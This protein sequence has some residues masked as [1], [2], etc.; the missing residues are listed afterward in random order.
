MISP[1]VDKQHGT[2]RA[3]AE[4][5]TRL[6]RKHDV[7]IDLYAQRVTDELPLAAPNVRSKGIGGAN[8]IRWHRVSSIPGPHLFQF[9]WWHFANRFRRRADKRK[10]RESP[11]LLYSPGIN[12]SDAEAITVHVVFHAHHEKVGEQ[13]RLFRHSPSQWPVLIH[14]RLYYR[15]LRALERRVYGDKGVALSAV[16][17]TI[18]K[19]MKRFF[20]RSDVLVIRHGVDITE[21]NSA[22]RLQ[23]RAAARR[24]FGISPDEY[25]YLLIGNDWK[26]KGLDAL[27]PAL[28]AC[29]D[30]RVRLLVVGKDAREPYLEKCKKLGTESR[31]A[32]LEPSADVMQFYAAADAYVGPSLED[33][34]GLPILESMACGLPVIASSAAG[35]S[36][37][38]VDGENGLLLRDPRD[39]KLLASLMRKIC[40]DSDLGS[41]LGAAAER[42][43]TNESW[44]AYASR[45]FEHFQS[46]IERKRQLQR[47]K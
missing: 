21:F 37:I 30:L 33:A 43:A 31:V 18:A 36:E 29:A 8:E 2:E 14:R 28:A 9:V 12:A 19:Q 27:L 11:D 34:Y 24:L 13:L 26:N 47:R 22:A 41:A 4:L 45:M 10:T 5:L 35:A 7:Q 40:V 32:F 1:F 23:R 17:Q 20:G 15:L 39:V 44:E 38:V 16:S 46:I 25:V 3:L 42:T 6:A